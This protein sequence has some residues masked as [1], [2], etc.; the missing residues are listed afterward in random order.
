MYSHTRAPTPETIA[1]SCLGARGFW[2]IA[3]GFVTTV[4]VVFVLLFTVVAAAWGQTPAD[5][6][7]RQL[8]WQS[9]GTATLELQLAG[10]ATGPVLDVAFSSD[11]GQ[12][13]ALTARSEVWATSDLGRSWTR[14]GSGP[15]VLRPFLR[16]AAASPA[17]QRAP[18]QDPRAILLQHPFDSGQVYALAEDVYRSTD[19]GRNWVNLTA[20]ALGSVIGARPRAMAFSPSDPNLIVVANAL[21]LWSSTDG[22][23]SWSDLNLNFPNLPEARIWRVGESR[24]GLLFASVGFAELDDTGRWRPAADER[25]QNWLRAVSQLPAADQGRKAAW[26]LDAPAGWTLSYRVWRDGTPVSADLTACA[27][28]VCSDPEKHF[29][30]AFAGAGDAQSGYFYAG[31]SD[32]HLW[33]SSDGGRSWRPAMQNFAANGAPVTAIF[34]SGRDNRVALAVAGGRGAGHVFRTT[35]GGLFWDDLTA[36][37]PDAPVRAVAASPETGSIYVGSEAGVFYTRGD[38]KNPGAA[39]RWTRLGG[40]LP[41]AAVDDL[42]LNQLTG[43]LYVAVSGYGL[44]RTAVPDIADSLRV[45]NAADLSARAA[46]PG[47]LLT[48]IGAP[49]TA[50]RAGRTMAPV[51]ATGSTDAQ[52][53]VPF[54]ATGST[55]DLTLETR[56]GASRVDVPLLPVSPAIF[57]DGDGSP[58]VLDAGSGLLL[59][60]SRPARAGSQVLILATGLGRVRP[61][62]P[63][64]L[65]APLENPPETIAPVAAYLDGAPLRVLSSTLASGYI[66][67]YL[68]RAE[69]PAIV[70]SGTAELSLIAADKTSNRVRIFLEP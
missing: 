49:V 46:A 2:R 37:L 69:L 48:V 36:N 63:T 5:L 59:D 55:V 20:D 18:S 27:T 33:V 22:G 3:A 12:L 16:P 45:L 54:E 13:L 6:S 42:R 65:A 58:L 68:V 52:I 31:T 14:S 62:W 40:N 21:G 24:P 23:L 17:A 44:Y 32:G 29:I 66:G 19:Q 34:V 4:R 43:T 70:N 53:Q 25:L 61:D 57:I 67:V 10:P 51:L 1:R 30:S 39:T 26:P 7:V 56:L 64:G 50:A 41:P 38:L 9:V 35:N 15:E 8:P 11:G 28:A 47:G 60:S